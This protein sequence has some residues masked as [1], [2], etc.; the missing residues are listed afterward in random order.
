MAAVEGPLVPTPR[1]V[2]LAWLA[3]AALFAVV[4][5]GLVPEGQWSAPWVPSLLIEFALRV[6]GLTRLMLALIS[7]VGTAVFFYA[8]G[9]LAGD[10]RLPRLMA[11]LVAFFLAMV[12]AVVAD[13]PWTLLLFWEATSVLSFLL[14]GFDRANRAARDAARHALLITGFGGLC[15]IGGLL[16]VQLA[17]P[18]LKLSDLT[19]LEGAHPGAL[20]SSLFHGGVALVVI[21]AL[22][23]SAQ[24]PFHAWLPGAMTA[25]TPV[26]AYLHSATMVKLGV[27]LLA[28]FDP[29]MDAVPWWHH[30]LLAV[31]A[32]TAV[33]A[34][35][36]TLRERDL[37]R[38]LAW[39]T[40]AALGTLTM[41]LGLSDALSGV[42]FTAFLLAH[43]LYKAPLFFVAG[44]VD[45]EAGTRQIDHLRGMRKALP[46]TAAAAVLAGAS[47]AGLPSSLGVVAKDA[48]QRA[49]DSVDIDWYVS[50]TSIAVSVVAV[51]VAAVATLRV[52]FGP[53]ND[54]LARSPHPQGLRMSLPPIALAVVGLLL[55][56]WHAPIEGALLA[57]ARSVAPFGELELEVLWPTR[58]DGILLAVVGGALLFW[59]WDRVHRWLE[60][61]RGLDA[62]GPASLYERALA[63]LK[64]GAGTVTRTAQHGVLGRYVAVLALAGAVWALPFLVR[65]PL[66]AA[67]PLSAGDAGLAAGCLAVLA[68]AGLAVVARD[69]LGRLLGAGLV[70]LGSAVV[71]LFG[72][73]PDVAFTQLAVETV[74]VVVAATALARY[75]VASDTPPA[76]KWR[77]VAAVA[78]GG[79]LGLASLVVFAAP[80]DPSL[81]NFFGA[82]SLPEAHGRNVTNVVLVDFRAFDTLGEIAVLLLVGVAAL[83]LLRRNTGKG[84]KA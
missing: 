60:G 71:F 73:A 63:A 31:G 2:Q 13:D 17:A 68:G 70:G 7:G 46:F 66:P 84:A 37:K 67:G 20:G 11:L 54:E 44:N 21:G 51:A 52:F 38:I 29:A 25:P 27:Y 3:P 33:F 69:V 75:R 24:F 41:L 59:Q 40:V 64:A 43:A 76:P 72:G 39:S 8:P 56:L 49:K 82:A 77:L 47:M 35:V 30:T 78:L 12:G 74:F 28:R 19:H 4:A 16:L 53:P 5:L 81:T 14:V 22:T 55:G 26:S 9:Y 10:A 15:L 32:F 23:K 18:G 42:A 83:P 61:F 36:Q 50:A 79:L 57:A 62:I 80:F 1:W 6:D 48:M 58:L 45:H 65:A 34:S